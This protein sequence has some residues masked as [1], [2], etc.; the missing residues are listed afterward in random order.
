MVTE[1][2]RITL[3]YNDHKTWFL[4]IR[5]VQETDRGWYMCQINTEPMTS[6][7][8]YLQVVGKISNIDNR[9]ITASSI[10]TIISVP[11]K[12]IEE[13]SSMDIIVKEGSD[14]NLQCK[15][16]GY[17]EPYIMWRR[18]D[19]LNINYNGITGKLTLNSCI[20]D[21]I[22]LWDCRNRIH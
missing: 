17:P 19:G 15:A 12:V 22:I 9:V 8:G 5:K 20:V 3:S 1:N 16:Q 18:E 2:A 10:S 6:Q 13:D 11:P 4:H 21:I 7:K 14:M